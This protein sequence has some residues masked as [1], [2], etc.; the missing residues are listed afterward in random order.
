MYV[1]E[2]ILRKVDGIGGRKEVQTTGKSFHTGLLTTGLSSPA[3][4]PPDS[5]ASRS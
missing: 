4:D 5:F 1:I 2:F 3:M